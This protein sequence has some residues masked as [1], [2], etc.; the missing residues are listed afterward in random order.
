M[1]SHDKMYF[2]LKNGGR[3]HH[4]MMDGPMGLIHLPSVDKNT[5]GLHKPLQDISASHNGSIFNECLY[6]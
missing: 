4:T 6:H 5:N 3:S 1:R 2:P